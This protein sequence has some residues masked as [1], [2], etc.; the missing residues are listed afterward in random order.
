MNVP[1]GPSPPRVASSSPGFPTVARRSARAH[2][3][4]GRA[5]GSPPRRGPPGRLHRLV[6]PRHLEPALDGPPRRAGPSRH[7]ST[8]P[9]AV[10][11]H[12]DGPGRRREKDRQPVGRYRRLRG[13]ARGRPPLGS[14]PIP[15]RSR[16]EGPSR[17]C[18]PRANGSG[19]YGRAAQWASTSRSGRSCGAMSPVTS[20]SIA[21]CSASPAPTCAS[22]PKPQPRDPRP[23]RSS[24]SC[25]SPPSLRSGPRADARSPRDL[26][27]LPRYAG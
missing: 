22:S 16:G 12:R 7:G 25:A 4:R 3:A 15:R 9:L 6:G 18:W 10:T 24:T 21:T 23:P 26:A 20:S 1:V 5:P 2:P 14:R 27:V 8:E 11:R 19:S 13:I 17:S